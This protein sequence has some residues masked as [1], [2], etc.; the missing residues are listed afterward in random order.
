M[1]VEA[2]GEVE[3]GDAPTVVAFAAP[4]ATNDDNEDD[5]DDE[6]EEEEA[7]PYVE[8]VFLKVASCLWE[9]SGMVGRMLAIHT[10]HMQ[11]VATPYERVRYSLT[12]WEKGLKTGSKAG[13][14][15]KGEPG[16]TE[17]EKRD[18]AD[19]DEAEEPDALEGAR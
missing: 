11:S 8:K 10:S 17:A 9:K 7:S 3:E 4:A 13:Q 14:S 12:R 16:P 6:D 15:V 2:D 1:G 5:E 18:G 19:V